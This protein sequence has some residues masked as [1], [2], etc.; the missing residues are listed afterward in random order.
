MG[1]ASEEMRQIL[2]KMKRELLPEASSSRTAV[3]TGGS[4]SLNNS[5]AEPRLFEAPGKS[6]GAKE[7]GLAGGRSLPA[8]MASADKESGK[9]ELIARY[10]SALRHKE[11]EHEKEIRILR[12]EFDQ[13]RR[14]LWGEIDALEMRTQSGEKRN[15]DGS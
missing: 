3:K 15:S 6:A 11:T 13:E 9:Q 14:L 4:A 10:E 1:S 7:D 5:F 8:A 2:E 12:E